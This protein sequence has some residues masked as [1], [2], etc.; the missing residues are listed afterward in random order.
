M[1]QPRHGAESASIPARDRT[2]RD[3][4]VTPEGVVR[5][6]IFD[7]ILVYAVGTPSNVIN[8]AAPSGSGT[9]EQS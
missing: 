6:L 8:P 2:Q 4:V 7:Q 1:T 3:P 5:R 9:K